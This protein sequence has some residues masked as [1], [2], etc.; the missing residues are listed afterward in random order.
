MAEM[1]SKK[2]LKNEK[3]RGFFYWCGQIVKKNHTWKSESVFS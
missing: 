3:R 1:K 2:V